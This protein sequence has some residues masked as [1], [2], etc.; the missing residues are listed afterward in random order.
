[1]FTNKSV[2]AFYIN[3]L[4]LTSESSSSNSTGSGKHPSQSSS[5]T[6]KRHIEEEI[7]ALLKKN[8]NQLTTDTAGGDDVRSQLSLVDNGSDESIAMGLEKN[9]PLFVEVSS[10]LSAEPSSSEPSISPSTKSSSSNVVKH[11]FKD[12]NSFTNS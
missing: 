6:E 2:E 8:E 9:I 3:Q 5:E 7:Q 12:L 11:Y 4:F 1:M 10:R